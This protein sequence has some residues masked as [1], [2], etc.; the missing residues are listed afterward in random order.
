MVFLSDG[1]TLVTSSYRQDLDV[2]DVSNGTNLVHL[3][4]IPA[5]GN[6]I[7]ALAIAPDGKTLVTGCKDST[8]KV[9][10][11]DVFME[12]PRA[13]DRIEDRRIQQSG[14]A[15]QGRLL[16]TLTGN[17][18]LNFWDTQ[19]L[20]ELDR[21]TA[22]P[23]IETSALSPDGSQL[24]AVLTNGA[25]QLWTVSLKQ[26]TPVFVKELLPPQPSPSASLLTWSADGKY[27]AAFVGDVYVW[28]T[29]TTRPINRLPIMR[30]SSIFFGRHVPLALSPGGR[31]LA[32]GVVPE[33]ARFNSLVELWDVA[34]GRKLSTCVGHKEWTGY[35]AFSPD[36]KVLASSNSDNTAK[37]WHVPSGKLKADLTSHTSAVFGVA[38]SPDGRT[39]VTVG[40]DAAKLWNVETGQE[41]MTLA[42]TGSFSLFSSDGRIL[43][44]AD[45]RFP[46]HTE[47]HAIRFWRAPS[48]V[49]INLAEAAKST[50]R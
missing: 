35:L 27:L 36:G 38:F 40:G 37:L 32:A 30:L 1:K 13:A 29:T 49:E 31:I 26:K 8:I 24:A 17:A 10:A 46:A 7:W 25:V 18:S 47:G 11:A 14:F 45:G 2:W 39:L 22:K 19:T 3:N 42:Q 43:A 16:V 5:H 41:L 15:E 6:E 28:N 23:D 33:G 20:A 34:S 48:F 21:Q 44:F 50:G 12:R 9:W 4:T